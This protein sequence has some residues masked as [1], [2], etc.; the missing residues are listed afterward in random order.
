MV[1]Q[2]HLHLPVVKLLFQLQEELQGEQKP[3]MEEEPASGHRK[4]R[5][6][7]I[8]RRQAD[9]A[10][11]DEHALILEEDQTTPKFLAR[12]L[13]MKKVVGRFRH[14]STPEADFSQKVLNGERLEQRTFGEDIGKFKPGAVLALV[15]V[16]GAVAPN[17]YVVVKGCERLPEYEGAQGKFAKRDTVSVS[18]SVSVS[19][20]SRRA[21]DPVSGHVGEFRVRAVRS[22]GTRPPRTLFNNA[23]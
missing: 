10:G 17:Q 22:C 11:I 13:F 23:Q 19:D 8:I 6:E 18:V 20:L 1:V 9:H 2:L 16:P 5:S 7:D 3:E 21:A 14:I 15:S 4:R 12:M